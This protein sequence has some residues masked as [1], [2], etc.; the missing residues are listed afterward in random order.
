MKKILFVIIVMS[1]TPV[2]IIIQVIKHEFELF[3]QIFEP[4]IDGINILVQDMFKFWE[5]IFKGDS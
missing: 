1:L 4:V 5:K 3:S 2:Y